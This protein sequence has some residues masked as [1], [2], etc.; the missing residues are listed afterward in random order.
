[1]IQVLDRLGGMGEGK[2]MQIGKG[3]V[4]QGSGA[5]SVLHLEVPAQP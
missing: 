3:D 2:G 4:A 5:A 1:M